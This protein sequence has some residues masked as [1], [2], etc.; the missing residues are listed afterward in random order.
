MPSNHQ[1][2]RSATAALKRDRDLL[3]IGNNNDGIARGDP[4]DSIPGQGNV[5]NASELRSATWCGWPRFFSP[6]PDG[7]CATVD[8]T[9]PALNRAAIAAPV[10]FRCRGCAAAPFC[11]RVRALPS[12][13]RDLPSPGSGTTDRR[14]RRLSVRGIASIAL[15]HIQHRTGAGSKEDT[16]SC[17]EFF[18][19][20]CR[21]G[22]P[23]PL[24]VAVTGRRV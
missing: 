18:H 13:C 10:V 22:L 8:L 3:A 1:A 20:I 12:A 5:V 21:R 17:R 4:S 2:H 11:R 19:D 9:K 6:V 24:L 14:C 16:A 15:H 7:G 23:D